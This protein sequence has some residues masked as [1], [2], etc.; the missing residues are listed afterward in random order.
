MNLISPTEIM[1][2]VEA[3]PTLG[4][5]LSPSRARRTQTRSIPSPL[6]TLLPKL[7]ND[8]VARLPY[9]PDFFPGA[10]DVDTPFGS[11][12][13]YELGPETGR[14]VLMIPGDTTPAPAFG[15]IAP[16]MVERGFRVMVFG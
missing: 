14:K 2:H 10:R 7:S 5:T 13:V 9:P 4:Y 6:V 1:L 3:L 8:Q 15:L 11:M 12:R 16:A